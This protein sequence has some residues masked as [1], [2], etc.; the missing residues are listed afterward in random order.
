MKEQTIQVKSITE[1]QD[2][3]AL[4]SYFMYKRIPKRTMT[5][6]YI[7][8]ASFLL[9]LIGETQYGLPFFKPLGI[10]GIIIDALIY[11][12]ITIETRPLETNQRKVLNIKQELN[13]DENGLSVK[14][15]GFE[16]AD[17]TWPEMK[18]AYENDFH[19]FIF[20]EKDFAVVLPKVLMKGKMSRDIHELLDR[21]L[22]LINE[23][24]DY[25]YM[26]M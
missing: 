4:R 15:E 11:S 6:A 14:W 18:F 24:K 23:S 19:Y 8:I 5:I 17:Y 13:L 21:H 12:W 25:E 10:V 3:I 7:L 1:R 26:N 9:L 22:K 2:Y 20:I 16:Q